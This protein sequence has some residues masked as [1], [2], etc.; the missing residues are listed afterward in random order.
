MLLKHYW[1]GAE[2]IQNR[3]KIKSKFKTLHCIG[4][5]ISAW[6]KSNESQKKK[7]K[8]KTKCRGCSY[9]IPKSADPR[10]TGTDV[11]KR[12]DSIHAWPWFLFF[13]FHQKYCIIIFIFFP[14]LVSRWQP[15]WLA[16]IFI[17]LMTQFNS[18]NYAGINWVV[19]WK[20]R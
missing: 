17:M 5:D 8:H 11:R 9:S 13:L 16:G 15:S 20:D 14:K 6:Q 18:F 12:C 19:S 7:K 4:C 2:K 1:C 10:N 3:R